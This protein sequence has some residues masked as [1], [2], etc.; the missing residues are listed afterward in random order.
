MSCILFVAPSTTIL[1]GCPDEFAEAN[2][3]QS[4]MNLA[5]SL[6]TEH[7]EK[8]ILYVLSLD[9]GASLVVTVGPHP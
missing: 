8:M 6:V 2:P 3:S 4:V 7:I 5:Q 9:H 1:A